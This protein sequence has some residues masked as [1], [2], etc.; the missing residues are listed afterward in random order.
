M[1]ISEIGVYIFFFVSLYFEV[2]ILLTFLENK[3]KIDAERNH[4]LKLDIW[5]AVTIVMPCFNEETT[6]AGTVQ[7]LL[8]LDYPAEKLKIM[9]VDDGSTDNTWNIIQAYKNHPQIF[10]HHKEN[11][12]KHTALNFAL[13]RISTPY[14]GCLDAD[15]FVE[16]K[17]LKKIMCK[18]AEVPDA[19]AVTPAMTI[20]KPKSLVQYMQATEYKFG[21]LVKK[22]LG[23]VNAI[24]VT[25]GPFSIFKVEV[26]KKIGNY[27]KAHNTE[28][29]EI[30][31]RM[32]K[33]HMKI[34][35][36]FNAWVYTTGPST[37]KKLYKQRVR[38]TT[39]FLG[40]ARDYKTM[41]F[42]KKYGNVGMITLP[43]GLILIFGVLFSLTLFVTNI[44]KLVNSKYH[45]FSAAGLSMPD[46]KL[47]WFYINTGLNVFLSITVIGL[48]VA[49]IFIAQKMVD[50]KMRISKELL[51]YCFLFPF[52]SPFWVAKSVYNT[53][54]AK[55]APWR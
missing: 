17:T 4:D 7:S 38:W 31:F 27:R 49:I 18:F 48:T 52:I 3:D 35:N 55:K 47:S 19:M 41:F 37:V 10:I 1:S 15:S 25:P 53:V 23:Y 9:I 30:A 12:G 11:G 36:V 45:Q 6:V 24:H 33:N 51:S 32:Q 28:D 20:Y 40:N 5:P 21:I 50:G 39:G 14:I 44:V 2:F 46:F 22:A 26:F 29:M 42:N 54:M 34:E 43:T 8:A 16:S 13:E